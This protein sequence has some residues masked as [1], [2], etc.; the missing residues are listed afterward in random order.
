MQIKLS[1]KQCKFG[2]TADIK[3][4][5]NVCGT[6]FLPYKIIT[7][8]RKRETTEKSFGDVQTSLYERAFI[9]EI[10]QI[11]ML[12]LT[13]APSVPTRENER[14]DY[15]KRIISRSVISVE[16]VHGIHGDFT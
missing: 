14:R 1:A 7:K 12:A 11:Q 13:S 3:S 9:L 10:L 16:R 15:I 4:L 8:K 6:F 2:E 5:Y